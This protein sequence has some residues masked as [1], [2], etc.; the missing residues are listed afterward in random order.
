MAALPDFM[1]SAPASAATFGRLS[2]IIPMTPMGTRTREI[3]MPLGR[4]HSLRVVPTGSGNP[5]MSSRPLA[6]ASTRSVVR[7]RRSMNESFRSLVFAAATSAALA[8]MSLFAEARMAF[9]MACRAAFFCWVEASASTPAALRAFRPSS[10]MALALTIGHHQIIAMND[11]ITASIANGLFD[12]S[13]LQSGD[14][15]GIA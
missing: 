7:T 3:F 6:M 11:F 15:G 5:A 1:H 10:C 12:V 14:A 9:A 4:V 2:K 8:A 13:G